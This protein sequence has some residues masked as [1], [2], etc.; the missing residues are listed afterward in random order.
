MKMNTDRWTLSV[1]QSCKSLVELRF[2]VK[3]NISV[4]Y[5]IKIRSGGPETFM[6]ARTAISG[7]ESS[8]G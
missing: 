2:K 4:A 8:H 7:D 5:L 3:F 1:E 6:S